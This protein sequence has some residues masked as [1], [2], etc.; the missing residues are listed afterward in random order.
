MK[1]RLLDHFLDLCPTEY[2]TRVSLDDLPFMLGDRPL[3]SWCWCAAAGLL[4]KSRD[5]L[6]T[7]RK[8]STWESSS[9]LYYKGAIVAP[10]IQARSTQVASRISSLPISKVSRACG[11]TYHDQQ[12]GWLQQFVEPDAAHS[13]QVTT[14]NAQ[15]IQGQSR[16]FS[17]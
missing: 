16:R 9:Q 17:P 1:Q 13:Q 2:S 11:P 15:H 3:C 10:S 8:G 5:G 6:F 4:C 14:D 7:S 12:V